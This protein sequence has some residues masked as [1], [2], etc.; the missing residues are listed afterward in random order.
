MQFDKEQWTAIKELANSMLE[1]SN[2]IDPVTIIFAAADIRRIEINE[3]PPPGD[4]PES[5]GG[6][7][8]CS[9]AQNSVVVRD[10]RFCGR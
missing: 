5:A 9:T 4:A 10:A 2:D 6:G 1:V 3:M 7:P 8:P